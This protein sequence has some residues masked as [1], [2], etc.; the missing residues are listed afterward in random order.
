MRMRQIFGP[1]LILRL[2][3]DKRL[4]KENFL[5]FPV[6]HLTD[7]FIS[8]SQLGMDKADHFEMVPGPLPQLRYD[9]GSN[10]HA[11]HSGV[12]LFLPFIQ[13]LR[14]EKIVDEWIR[15]P[16]IITQLQRIP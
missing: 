4:F 11:D 12:L 15:Q 16:I 1:V 14:V 8:L 3:K 13:H 5:G 10:R 2:K 7:I 9:P 6:L